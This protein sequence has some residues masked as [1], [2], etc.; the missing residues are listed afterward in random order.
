MP[1][2]R[3]AHLREPNETTVVV[4][5]AAPAP[6]PTPAAAPAPASSAPH[7]PVVQPVA[8]TPAPAPAAQTAAPTKPPK[9][10]AELLSEKGPEEAQKRIARAARKAL[11]AFGIDIPKDAD[12][13]A[14]AE[15]Y[16]ADRAAKKSERRELR[17]KAEQAD[18]Y[19]SALDTYAKNEVAA[20]SEE[21]RA[22]VLGVAPTDARAQLAHI[23]ALRQSGALKTAAP[24]APEAPA[25]PTAPAAPPPL[26]APAQ[27]APTQPGPVQ[28]TPP[29]T[30]HF[31]EWN[32]LKADTS[33]MSAVQASL[34]FIQ[35]QYEIQS[36]MSRR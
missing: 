28:T 7:A 23:S 6:S 11:K 13:N 3:Q 30:D 32:R 4:T 31:A 15:R 8:P 33:P 10:L 2:G 22:F 26:P 20:L 35:H 14:E 29:V 27:S 16:K 21:Q 19:R 1:F 9:T 36:S 18:A 24:A 34:Y 5:P 12:I 17:E 25:A